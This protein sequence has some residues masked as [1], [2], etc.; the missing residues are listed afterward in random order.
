MSQ[1]DANLF[2]CHNQKL[3]LVAQENISFCVTRKSMI[4]ATQEDI[5][6]FLHVTQE[7]ILLVTQE[8][9]V[10]TQE[11]FLL[12]KQAYMSSC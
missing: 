6:S 9:A 5:P 3:L 2:L 11:D 4:L 7:D 12:V 1:G 10:M 8:N